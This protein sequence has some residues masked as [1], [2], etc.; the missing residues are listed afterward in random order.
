LLSEIGDGSGFL[1]E[2][3]K[4][5]PEH[6]GIENDLRLRMGGN[7]QAQLENDRCESS[8]QGFEEPFRLH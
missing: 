4:L 7:G 5:A 2:L 1:V 3:L 6:A 8:G